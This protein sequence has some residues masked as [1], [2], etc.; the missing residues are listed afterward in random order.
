M[1]R[2]AEALSNQPLSKKVFY[3]N[4][5]NGHDKVLSITLCCSLSIELFQ[6]TFLRDIF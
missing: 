2:N 4:F 5:V 3:Q 1:T 6:C